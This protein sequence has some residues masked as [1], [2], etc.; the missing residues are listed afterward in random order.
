MD[1]SEARTRIGAVAVEWLSTPFHDNAEVKGAGVDCARLLKVVATEAGVIAPFKLDHY[2]PQHFLHSSEERFLGWVEKF[3]R[4]IPA[5]KAKAGDVVLYRLKAS[6]CFCHGALIVEPGWPNIIHAH[7]AA[8]RVRRGNGLQP[9]LG[10]PVVAMKFFSF[11]EAETVSKK[12][13]KS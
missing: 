1:E 9:H 13:S 6:K 3:G 7:F 10:S 2:S 11:F 8:R 4:E 5:E 12:K